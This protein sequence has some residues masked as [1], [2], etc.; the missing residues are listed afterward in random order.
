MNNEDDTF[1]TLKKIPLEQALCEFLQDSHSTTEIKI[2]DLYFLLTQ[3]VSIVFKPDG[4]TNESM[5]E[6]IEENYTES[7]CPSIFCSY[8]LDGEY[9]NYPILEKKNK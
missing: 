6:Y 8:R 3:K 1:K 7:R 9:V 4:W 2:S 5:I